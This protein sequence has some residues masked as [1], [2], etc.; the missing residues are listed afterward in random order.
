MTRYLQLSI[1]GRLMAYWLIVWLGLYPASLIG[2]S[3]APNSSAGDVGPTSFQEKPASTDGVGAGLRPLEAV[4]DPVVEVPPALPAVPPPSGRPTQDELK[5]QLDAALAA[6]LDEETKSRVQEW[7]KSAAERLTRLEALPARSAEFQQR[8][9]SADQRAEKARETSRLS[10]EPARF[11]LKSSSL[12]DVQKEATDT[13]AQLR[14]WRERLTALDAERDAMAERR[15]EILMRLATL[16]ERTTELRAQLQ[17]AAPEGESPLVT[18]ARRTSQ[19]IHLAL[20][21]AEMPVLA[22]ER[23]YIDG[24]IARDII[25]LERDALAAR[26]DI[27]SRWLQQVNELVNQKRATEAKQALQQAESQRITVPPKLQSLADEIQT[28]AQEHSDLTQTLTK[29]EQHRE[30]VSTRLVKLREQFESDQKKVQV[31]LTTTIGY[32]LRKQRGNIPTSTELQGLQLSPGQVSDA[33]LKIFQLDEE[34][35]GLILYDKLAE[36][37]LGLPATTTTLS[38]SD[39]TLKR[40][41]ADLLKNKREALDNLYRSYESYFNALVDIDTDLHQLNGLASRYRNYIDERILWIPSSRPILQQFD[42]SSMDRW[43][44]EL[45][46]WQELAG[47]LWLDSL[48]AWWWWFLLIALTATVQYRTRRWRSVITALGREASSGS[49]A[50]FLPTFKSLG[51]TVLISLPWPFLLWYLGWRIGAGVDA[52]DGPRNEIG[53]RSI[54]QGL[55]AAGLGLLPLECLRNICRENGLAASHFGWMPNSLRAFGRLL[56]NVIVIGLPLVFIT[57]TLH[58]VDPVMSEDLLERICF[59]IGCGVM[60]YAGYRILEPQT[61]LLRTYYAKHEGGWSGRLRFIWFLLGMF[62][63]L[64]LA[65]LTMVGY[66]YTAYQLSLRLYSMFWLIIGLLIG[67]EL[68]AR[69]I[70]VER[71]RAFIEQAKQRRAQAAATNENGEKV[72]DGDVG[73]ATNIDSQKDWQEKLAAQTQQSQNL[74]NSVVIMI[75]VVGTWFVWAD[76]IP[77]LKVLYQHKLWTTIEIVSE[78]PTD[79]VDASEITSKEVIRNITSTDLLQAVLVL[80]MTVVVFRN[81]PG[82][83]DILVLNQLPLDASTRNAIAAVISYLVIVIGLVSA[84][85]LVGI[86]WN[87]VQWLVTA[88]TFGLAFGLQEIFANFVS[89]MIILFERPVRVGDVVTVDGVTGV[90]TRTR[91]RATTIRDFDLKELIVPNKEFITG[92][93]L[94]WTLTDEVSRLLLPVG[95]AYGSDVE[96]ASRLL[97]EATQRHPSV[98]PEP[99]P[100][101]NFEAF[102][103]STLDLVVRAYV[104]K[105]SDRLRVTSELLMAFNKTLHEHG[106]EIAFP[107]RDLHIRTIPPE[108]SKAV[109]PRL[110]GDHQP[111]PTD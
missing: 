75:A 15:R 17:V 69:W 53:L 8:I 55:I 37:Y 67:S 20:L 111:N 63:P 92:R 43:L 5:A 91:A 38:E 6:N 1:S 29:I 30:N 61:G 81:L 99:A 62:A 101:V 46:L 32:L 102:G 31:G 21:E 64:A 65:V 33:Q 89:G 85:R 51:Y 108:W 97:L 80:V 19:Q 45:D 105:L 41:A 109:P 93:V 59:L 14:Q 73:V 66:Y 94:N 18:K 52:I 11:D 2:Q 82:L 83:I 40:Q 98:L 49:C 10:G 22:L 25:R 79:G 72:A 4:Q 35:K 27:E 42:F 58:W 7:Y 106:I 24:E 100:S 78:V 86:Y 84:A 26:I 23:D 110:E 9:A 36:E 90:V 39:R 107:Q 12:A 77:A 56:R 68:I 13:E 70:L 47:V 60:L 103:D 54:G 3:T 76:V 50:S 74:L 88:L 96:L 104:G 87:Q 28:I 34:R 48:T 44:F 95:I 16:P 57:S 71:R